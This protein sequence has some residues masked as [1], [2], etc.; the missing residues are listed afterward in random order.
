MPSSY[1][2]NNTA[3]SDSI[4]EPDP[5]EAGKN[6]SG[7]ERKHDG[8]DSFVMAAVQAL[9]NSD[10]NIRNVAREALPKLAP[11]CIDAIPS[12][13]AALETQDLDVLFQIIQLLGKFG[14]KAHGAGPALVRLTRHESGRIRHNAYNSLAIIFEDVINSDIIRRRNDSIPDDPENTGMVEFIERH[15]KLSDLPQD[16]KP[17]SDGDG[18][19]RRPRYLAALLETHKKAG[20]YEEKIALLENEKH[21]FNRQFASQ[22]LDVLKSEMQSTSRKHDLIDEKRAFIDWVNTEVKRMGLAFKNPKIDRPAMLIVQTGN[23]PEIGRFQLRTEQTDSGTGKSET[24]STPDLARLLEKLE[25][26]E[27]APRQE[28]WDA[29]RRKKTPGQQGGASPI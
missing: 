27:S 17:K 1:H 4:V 11:A 10:V 25:L 9:V 21:I 15:L 7:H 2:N 18:L 23:D 16:P 12:L 13:V 22:V 5:Q 20:T 8:V 19:D 3:Q 28:G 14:P 29:F 24:F 6:P 26:M